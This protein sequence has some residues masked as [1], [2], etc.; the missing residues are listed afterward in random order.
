MRRILVLLVLACFVSVGIVGCG[1][2]KATKDGDKA[3]PAVK[4]GEKKA[5][6]LKKDA[7]KAV[8]D[9]TKKAD[10]ALEGAAPK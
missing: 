6:D 1:G 7:G 4:D 5:G 9:A 2:G 10:K 3:T 8:D